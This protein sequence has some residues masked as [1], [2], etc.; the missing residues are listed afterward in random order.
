MPGVLHERPRNPKA[1]TLEHQGLGFRVIGNCKIPKRSPKKVQTRS[2][3][4]V[5][6]TQQQSCKWGYVRKHVMR[7]QGHSTPNTLGIH[8]CIVLTYMSRLMIRKSPP[9]DS[10]QRPIKVRAANDMHGSPMLPQGPR[11]LGYVGCRVWALGYVG[12]RV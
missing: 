6:Q 9:T 10:L 11:V 5:R 3:T 8:W 4:P 1:Q 2:P 7:F 12:S